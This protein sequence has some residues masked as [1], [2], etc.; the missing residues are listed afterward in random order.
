[1]THQALSGGKENGVSAA[2]QLAQEIGISE[3]RVVVAYEAEMVR[4]SGS[5]SVKPFLELLA[6]K[7]VKARLLERKS[8]QT[9]LPEELSG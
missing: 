4:L 1:M 9:Q 8:Q 7:H 3:D 2:R 5:A 6:L